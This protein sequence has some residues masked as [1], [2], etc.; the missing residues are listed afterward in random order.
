[1]CGFKSLYFTLSNSTC[2]KKSLSISCNIELTNSLTFGSKHKLTTNSAPYLK[3]DES[4]LK[5]SGLNSTE[6]N[7]TYLKIEQMTAL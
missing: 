7:G 6:A 5:V 1:M 2:K 3:T 4:V